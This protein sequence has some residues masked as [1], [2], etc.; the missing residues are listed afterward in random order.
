MS[1][2][3]PSSPEWTIARELY[4]EK[5][6]RKS[7]IVSDAF[8]LLSGIKNK[9]GASMKLVCTYNLLVLV[10]MVKYKYVDREMGF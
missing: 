6:R 8:S 4:S 10:V 5:D 2:R 9:N 7:K 1:F 3:S